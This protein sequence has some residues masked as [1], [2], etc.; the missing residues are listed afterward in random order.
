MSAEKLQDFVDGR[1]NIFRSLRLTGQSIDAIEGVDSEFAVISKDIIERFLELPERTDLI[2]LIAD[3]KK[4]IFEELPS[5]T[6]NYTPEEIFEKMSSDAAYLNLMFMTYSLVFEFTRPMTYLD[7]MQ[8]FLYDGLVKRTAMRAAGIDESVA[9]GMVQKV[10]PVLREQLSRFMRENYQAEFDKQHQI[11][12]LMAGCDAIKIVELQLNEVKKLFD[13]LAEEGR[14]DDVSSYKENLIQLKN[15]L[16]QLQSPQFKDSLDNSMIEVNMHAD[17]IRYAFSDKFSEFEKQL[18]ELDK[19]YSSLLNLG[20]TAE[21]QLSAIKEVKKIIP[22]VINVATDLSTSQDVA[23]EFKKAHENK[24]ELERLIKAADILHAKLLDGFEGDPANEIVNLQQKIIEL[25]VKRAA[26][27]QYEKTIDALMQNVWDIKKNV[28]REQFS[29]LVGFL[30]LDVAKYQKEFN[31]FTKIILKPL[32]K[33]KELLANRVRAE[34]EKQHS[35]FSRSLADDMQKL[36]DRKVAL[37]SYL[38]L[39]PKKEECEKMLEN[40]APALKKIEVHKN[41]QDELEF[42]KTL[43]QEAD[44]FVGETKTF[45]WRLVDMFARLFRLELE[46]LPMTLVQTR[47]AEKIQSDVKEHS[48]KISKVIE[49]SDDSSDKAKLLEESREVRLKFHARFFKD[50]NSNDAVKPEMKSIARRLSQGALTS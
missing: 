30:G 31:G 4:V 20:V 46:S 8:S 40:L 2:A 24:R 22:E 48:E 12:R 7:S 13:T 27:K 6:T 21:K 38:E 26:F 33:E 50:L 17:L 1:E 29:E 10:K 5:H 44:A 37:Q 45:L 39:Q 15:K 18:E 11:G 3:A 41:C 47:L 23:S 25:N 49:A 42:L 43:N 28:A 32:H 19:Q 9:D 34:F 14:Y 35:D 16:A 36:N